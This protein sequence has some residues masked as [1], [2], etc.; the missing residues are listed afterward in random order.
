[1]FLDMSS[2]ELRN[3]LSGVWQNAE[4]VAASLD[5]YI[6]FLEE[7]QDD[8]QPSPSEL[9][10]LL[11][12]MQE[13]VEA[14]DSIL[15][16]ASH[17][18]RIADDI[19][20]ISKLNMGLL[21]VQPVPFELVKRMNE[22]LRVFEVFVPFFSSPSS[23]FSRAHSLSFAVNA[24]KSRFS[25]RST[26]TSP[27]SDFERS[28]SRRILLASTRVRSSFPTFPLSEQRLTLLSRS[29]PQLPHQR[30]QVHQRCSLSPYHRS[31]SGLRDSA[32][33]P[34]AC[35]ASFPTS[36]Q[37]SRRLRMDRDLRRGFGSWIER[38][39][40]EEALCPLLAS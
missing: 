17:Q 27:S 6:D 4:V 24:R 34:S 28:G 8:H 38:R 22:V 32:A 16:C 26:L 29:S 11:T 20:S 10:H 12:E 3:P 21:S 25:S 14:V 40:A 7:L 35:D 30:H 15:L 13:N 36:R 9:E 39:R 31:H 23:P 18:Q 2:H 1:M 5:K 37:H 19:L 33:D